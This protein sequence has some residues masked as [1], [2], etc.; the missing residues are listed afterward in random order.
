[1]GDPEAAEPSASR[2]GRGHFPAG[3]P[4]ARPPAGSPLPARAGPPGIA[5]VCPAAARGATG[6]GRSRLPR[7]RAREASRSSRGSAS[8]EAVRPHRACNR[9]CAVFSGGAGCLHPLCV[10]EDRP[11]GGASRRP[12]R[13]APRFP[14]TQEERSA[15]GASGSVGVGAGLFPGGFQKSLRNLG[16]SPLFQMD[17]PT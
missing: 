4:G 12:V 3:F 5:G 16:S 1:M 17:S 6:L 8:H 7:P 13:Q 14:F 9:G 2:D 11:A 10:G 15:P